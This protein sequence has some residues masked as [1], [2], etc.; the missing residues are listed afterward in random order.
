M[1]NADGWKRLLKA[2]VEMRKEIDFLKTSK[3]D[4]GKYS[5]NFLPLEAFLYPVEDKLAEHG[6]YVWQFPDYIPA[7]DVVVV[8]TTIVDTETGEPL[9]KAEGRIGLQ[10]ELKWLQSAIDYEMEKLKKGSDNNQTK[11][12]LPSRNLTQEVGAAFSYAR[13]YHLLGCLGIVGESDNDAVKS[14]NGEAAQVTSVDP[15]IA[16]RNKLRAAIRKLPDYLQEEI[17]KTFDDKA[18]SDSSNVSKLRKILFY[19]MSHNPK[20]FPLDVL[21]KL[22]SNP[23]SITITDEMAKRANEFIRK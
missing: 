21:Q 12:R 16:V 13:R 9:I 3:V 20:E 18:L 2:T 10:T 7:D 8:H 1:A 22:I 23:D 19:V 4:L 17:N 5:Y 15:M 6:L 14:E 11:F